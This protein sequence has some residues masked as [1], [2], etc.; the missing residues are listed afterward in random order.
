MNVAEMTGLDYLLAMGEGRLPMAPMA[1][2]LGME[3][4]EAQEGR[5]V[6]AA[7][8]PRKG[9]TVHGQGCAGPI[10]TC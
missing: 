1:E 5:V 10:D 9:L 6:F 2:L 3:A 4:V 7:G 8:D